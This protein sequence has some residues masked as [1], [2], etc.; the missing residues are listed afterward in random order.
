MIKTKEWTRIILETFLEESGLNYRI[1]MGDERARIL[2][3]IMR[4]RFAGWSIAKQADEF[5]VSTDT[6]SK[7][8]KE[9]SKLYDETQKNSL[10]L[11][12]AKKSKHDKELDTTK[13]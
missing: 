4:T 9:L 11:P 1:E 3:G 13:M 5:H 2:E 12:T 8:V 10:I 6:I 7:Y